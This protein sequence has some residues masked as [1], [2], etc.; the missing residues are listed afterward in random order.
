MNYLVKEMKI[1]TSR[2]VI[3]TYLEEDL[4]ECFNLMQDKEL[5]TYLDMDVMSL[6]EY[7]RLFNWLIKSYDVGFDKDFKYSFNITLKENGKHIGW[8][9]IGGLNFDHA[10]KE[11]YYL[12]G[13]EYW[14]NGYA[15]EA[16]EALLDF[17]FN[18]MNLEE[19]VAIAQPENIASQ[20]VIK[21]MG[22]KYKYTLA[23]LPKEFDWNNGEFYY[24]LSQKEYFSIKEN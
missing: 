20:K 12:I 21:N 23:G 3:R 19:I 10:T 13:K 4:M 15:K 1:E 22:L 16:S 5:F 9:G 6:D 2:L 24:S 8:C 14:G 7:K 11:I 18:V 17:G